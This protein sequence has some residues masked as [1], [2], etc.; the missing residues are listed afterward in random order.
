V[1]LRTIE[2]VASFPA[3]F[4]VLCALFFIDPEIVPP[5]AAVALVIAL[6]GWTSVARLVRAECMRLRE[7][8]FVHA[9]R[10]LGLSP[11]R[12][13]ARHVLP[14]TLTPVLVALA[15]A[16]SAGI[17]TESALSFL[18]FGVQAPVPSWGSLVNDSK[19]ADHWWIWLFP[20]LCI[21]ATVVAYNLLGEALRDALD[22]KDASVQA[23]AE[24]NA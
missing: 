13:L 9:A 23:G 2:I 4:L 8:E 21:F 10:A 17:L 5:L 11:A 18:G 7:L 14:N 12:I 20:G 6:V 15:F 24:K 1:I 3:F 16:A 22:P 19:S